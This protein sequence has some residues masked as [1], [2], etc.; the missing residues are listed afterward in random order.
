MNE[1]ERKLKEVMRLIKSNANRIIEFTDKV[2][3]I[4]ETAGDK[5][6]DTAKINFPEATKYSENIIALIGGLRTE[7]SNYDPNVAERSRLEGVLINDVSK[8]IESNTNLLCKYNG[9]Y[10]EIHQK[11]KWYSKKTNCIARVAVSQSGD[12]GIDVLVG[13][14]MEIFALPIMY[15]TE[16]GKAPSINMVEKFN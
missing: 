3:K 8:K 10:L 16:A 1:S 15:L 6:V 9:F 4:I 5:H 12:I 13:M 11:N 14:P 7:L 2:D